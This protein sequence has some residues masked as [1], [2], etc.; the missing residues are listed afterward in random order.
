MREI[1]THKSNACNEAITLTADDTPG[2]GGAN[3]LYT[4]TW[5][6]QYRDGIPASAILPFQSGPVD[7]L[8]PNG[9]TNEALLAVLIDRL[10]GFQR[11]PFACHQNE[12][13]LAGLLT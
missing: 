10:E 11:G 8:G 4:I 1:T 3:D 12:V 9:L 6:K 2:P 5:R 7:R 13:A